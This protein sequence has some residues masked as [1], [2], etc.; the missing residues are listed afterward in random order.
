VT[1]V[2]L[3]ARTAPEAMAVHAAAVVACASL[4][5]ALP[6]GRWFGPVFLHPYERVPLIVR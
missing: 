4:L 5:A 1:D 6:A 3:I 2:R